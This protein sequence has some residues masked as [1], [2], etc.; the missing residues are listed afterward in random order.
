MATRLFQSGGELQRTGVD[1]FVLEWAARLES[2]RSAV[3]RFA[4][5]W[6]S[7]EHTARWTDRDWG[8]LSAARHDEAVMLDVVK[9]FART[10]ND[11]MFHE[12]DRALEAAKQ[13]YLYG[14]TPGMSSEHFEMLQA[15][16][17]ARRYGQ[18]LP[19]E[20]FRSLD[21]DLRAN[22]ESYVP[23]AVAHLIRVSRE[24]RD[25]GVDVFALRWVGRSVDEKAA[26]EALVRK[27]LS[28]GLFG[29][30]ESTAGW[31][32]RDW[33]VVAAAHILDILDKAPNPKPENWSQG[34]LVVATIREVAREHARSGSGAAGGQSS[35]SRRGPIVGMALVDDQ[36]QKRQVLEELRDG[37]E[38][39][40]AEYEQ[41]LTALAFVD[42]AASPVSGGGTAGAAVFGDASRGSGGVGLAVGADGAPG[43]VT[44]Q[45]PAP[46]TGAGG[47]VAGVG[48]RL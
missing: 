8:T 25:R 3:A 28:G 10:Y 38:K 7:A 44:T 39:G 4:H 46:V 27:T 30:S 24:L 21:E 14:R 26:V 32:Y 36:A 5:K 16:K 12:Y 29:R 15:A 48:D 1:I 18:R 34:A 47:G 17:A 13:S 45:H 23:A 31:T 42:P 40:S 35:G 41:V 37:F 11:R 19:S 6:V 20:A 2:E 22:R 43:N 9:Y 33:G